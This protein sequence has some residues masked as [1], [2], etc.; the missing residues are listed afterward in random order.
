MHQLGGS[1]EKASTRPCALT[2][3]FLRPSW[4][5]H[6]GKALEG[7]ATPDALALTVWEA[8]YAALCL[9]HVVAGGG[10]PL[11]HQTDRPLDLAETFDGYVLKVRAGADAESVAAAYLPRNV[12]PRR[13]R[14]IGA[15]LTTAADARD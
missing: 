6:T 15:L 14:L 8:S 7:G 1:R 10:R 4:D 5:F 11:H 2:W 12:S 3:D 9:V 13:K